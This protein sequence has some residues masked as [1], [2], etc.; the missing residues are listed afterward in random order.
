MMDMSERLS[1]DDDIAA[2]QVLSMG[3]TRYAGA[4]IKTAVGEPPP[5]SNILEALARA[6]QIIGAAVHLP[7]PVA[8]A[9]RDLQMIA[10]FF[11]MQ[12][13]ISDGHGAPEVLRQFGDKLVE[14]LKRGTGT[15]RLHTC[16]CVATAQGFGDRA[17]DYMHQIILAEDNHAPIGSDAVER[18][19]TELQI[20]AVAFTT[21]LAIAEGQDPHFCG[22][23]RTSSSRS[24]RTIEARDDHAPPSAFNSTVS[25]EKFNL[26]STR[27]CPC[28]SP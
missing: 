14:T 20:A 24:S 10:V 15:A 5:G 27:S 3:A 28:A 13:A 23:S 7:A 11:T 8:S 6:R 19:I 17:L 25:D 26:L 12:L 9:L 2:A 22:G 16:D 4:T 1:E 18:A 21:Q